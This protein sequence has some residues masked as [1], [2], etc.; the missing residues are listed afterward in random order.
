MLSPPIPGCPGSNLANKK[1]RELPL[2]HGREG[3]N[4]S[5]AFGGV[6]RQSDDEKRN[7]PRPLHDE[8]GLVEKEKEDPKLHRKSVRLGKAE[9]LQVFDV[10]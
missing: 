7:E 9:R 6:Q 5:K 1:E 4:I 3:S 8:D 2:I 10:P